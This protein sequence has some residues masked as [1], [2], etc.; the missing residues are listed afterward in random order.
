[1][2]I[3]SS[4]YLGIGIAIGLKNNFSAPATQVVGSMNQM[5]S[6]A[7]RA[8]RQQMQMVRDYNLIGS[9]LGAGA[10]I[11]IKNW[12]NVGAEFGYT[13]E[14]VKTAAEAT[15]EEFQK[16]DATAR[17]L[18]KQT[19]FS[20]RDVASGMKY[21]AMAG[22]KSNEINENIKAA[23]ALAGATQSEIGGKG[24]SADILTNIMMAFGATPDQSMRYA[25]VL[26]TATIKSNTDLADLGEAM[27]YSSSTLKTMGYSI[28]DAASIA[29]VLGNA[30]MQG[31][32]AGTAMENMVRYVTRAASEART[33]K[34][35]E[36]LNQLGLNPSQLIDSNG[37]LL[38]MREILKTIGTQLQGMGNVQQQ[39][40]LGDVFGVR[41]NRA[42][43]LII[44]NLGQIDT[45]YNDVMYNSAGISQNTLND[46]MNTLHGTIDRVI[47]GAED[48]KISW[49]K[50]VE[51]VLKL[52]LGI[53]EHLLNGVTAILNVPFIGPFI[54][55][56]VTGFLLLKTVTMGYR[57]AVAAIR[58]AYNATTSAMGVQTSTTVTGY[59]AMT[60]SAYRYAT[61]ARAAGVAN[62][63]GFAGSKSATTSSGMSAMMNAAGVLGVGAN[64]NFVR[65]LAN[66][67][68]VQMMNGALG[69][70]YMQM[71]GSRVTG[72]LFGR[73]MAGLGV[74]ALA[75]FLP[76]LSRGLSFLGG[77]LG[78][79]LGVG[80][81]ALFSGLAS[82]KDD[83][84]EELEDNTAALNANTRLKI[85]GQVIP[86]PYM[87]S[88]YNN[89]RYDIDVALAEK[90]LNAHISRR[91]GRDPNIN[92]NTH[93]DVWIDNEKAVKKQ[94]DQ[95]NL[96]EQFKMGM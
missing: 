55:T 69:A 27:K 46:M 48:F 35:G 5:T 10:L 51:P 74:P 63:M 76:L 31:S 44:R 52:G 34:Q 7:Q 58:M 6:A 11:G 24:G 60:A 3:F 15:N 33:G 38:N 2:S 81:P 12:V 91:E 54:A 57:G 45:M 36:A 83:N 73:T 71:Y 93:T 96:D 82:L 90:I 66:G 70:R 14:Y 92:V 77:P 75:R 65:R 88:S 67:K 95:K 86:E 39:N 47:S 89:R 85:N 62:A 49:T 28:E 78:L 18:G 4:G 23:T 72:G 19:M 20:S 43:A 61:A 53:I 32:L 64:G 42:A 37:N 87:Q 1:M 22:Q 26:T 40:I 41:G 79:L 21:M 94:I 16:L 29:M 13:M 56:S 50:G 84:N 9:T 30:G 25:D 59:N 8:M 17:K 80:L 68:I